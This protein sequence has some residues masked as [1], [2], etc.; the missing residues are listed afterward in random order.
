M[1]E[2]RGLA[3]SQAMDQAQIGRNSRERAGCAAEFVRPRAAGQ[4]QRHKNVAERI[5]IPHLQRAVAAAGKCV[6]ALADPSRI[7]K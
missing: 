2:F 4:L 6:L 1:H 5:W 7:G 3:T